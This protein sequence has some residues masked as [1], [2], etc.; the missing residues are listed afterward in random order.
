M[1][2]QRMTDLEAVEFMHSLSP[3]EAEHLPNPW[4]GSKLEIDGLVVIIEKWGYLTGKMLV[5]IFE[6]DEYYN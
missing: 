5:T 6:H 2:S 4:E 1:V 3:Y